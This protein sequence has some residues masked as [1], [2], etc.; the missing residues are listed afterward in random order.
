MTTTPKAICIAAALGLALLAGTPAPLAA[1]TAPPVAAAVVDRLAAEG[2]GVVEARRSWFGR[3]II[4]ATRD[5]VLREIV[6][7]RST[8][9]VLSD[10]LFNA[11]V[12]A[13]ARTGE[14]DDTGSPTGTPGPETRPNDGNGAH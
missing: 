8:G 13:P 11:G 5:G 14:P 3:L 10:R 4:L 1:Q 6:I 12:T 9:A 7:N 2:Y